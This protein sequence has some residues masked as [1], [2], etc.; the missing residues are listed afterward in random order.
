MRHHWLPLGLL[1]NLHVLKP[2][3]RQLVELL[4]LKL[5]LDQKVD[6]LQAYAVFNEFVLEL[7]LGQKTLHISKSLLKGHRE[8]VSGF[9]SGVVA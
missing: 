5:S 4:G 7:Q 9:D 1:Q 3:V 8:V 6:W 2:L